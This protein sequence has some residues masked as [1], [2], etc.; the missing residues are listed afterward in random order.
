MC[1]DGNSNLDVWSLAAIRRSGCHDVPGIEFRNARG[2]ARD[3]PQDVDLHRVRKGMG[4]GVGYDLEN[5]V[6]AEVAKVVDVRLYHDAF[7]IPNGLLVAFVKGELNIGFSELDL[8]PAGGRARMKE[9]GL[10]STAN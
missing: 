8:L 5:G 6:R 1:Q 10:F 4:N 9:S 7:D 3:P 2:L